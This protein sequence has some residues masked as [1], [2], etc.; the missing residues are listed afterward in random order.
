MQRE[1]L[2]ILLGV[3][4]ALLC[5]MVLY[6]QGS[7]GTIAGTIKDPT[8]AVIQSATVTIRNADTNVPRTAVTD[9][10]GHFDVPALTAGNYEVTAEHTGF[11]TVSQKGI[12]LTVSQQAVVNITL[13]VGTA[14][15]VVEVNTT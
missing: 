11:Q 7:D 14:S 12:V 5:P 15:Q 13:P 10:N 8:G 9:N 4:F 6:G 1:G 3:V 2:A